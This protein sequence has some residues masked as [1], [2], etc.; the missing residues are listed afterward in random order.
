MKSKITI[1]DYGVGNLNSILAAFKRLNYTNT[2]ISSDPKEILNSEALV[3]PG[4][5]AFGHCA[6]NLTDRGLRP[7]LN[8]AVLDHKKP[9]LGICVGMQLFGTWSEESQGA[10][11]LNWIPGVVRKINTLPN[12]SV[13]HVGWNQLMNLKQEGI[14]KNSKDGDNFYFDHSYYLDCSENFISSIVNYGIDLT[15]SVMKSNIHGVQFHPEKSQENGL[16][17]FNLFGKA[18]N[19]A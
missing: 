9:I 7:I 19:L 13:P 16:R 5:G 4:V 8:E 11:G 18:V 12:L 3:L 15:A 2:N 1:I 14:L 10:Q 6:Q 17:V